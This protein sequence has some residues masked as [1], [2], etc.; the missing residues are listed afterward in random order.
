MQKHQYFVNTLST[1]SCRL[2]NWSRR[3]LDPVRKLDLRSL[4]TTTWQHSMRATSHQLH[5]DELLDLAQDR[6]VWWELV[7]EWFVLQTPEMQI[8]L[9]TYLHSYLRGTQAICSSWLQPAKR[10]G[11]TLDGMVEPPSK[12]A[13]FRS[14]GKSMVTAKD[15]LYYRCFFPSLELLL[16]KYWIEQN[17]V[18]NR[19]VYTSVTD[20]IDVFSSLI[21]VSDV[22]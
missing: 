8:L 9:L 1:L 11:I 14:L 22:L 16:S 3:T 6:D 5:P 19:L 4:P 12:S 15:G 10:C 13:A 2:D 20:N 7:V 18:T 21:Y 17:F